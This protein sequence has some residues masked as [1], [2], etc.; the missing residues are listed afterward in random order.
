MLRGFLLAGGR[1]DLYKGF[2]GILHAYGEFL[3]VI[4]S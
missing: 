1:T 4:I 2:C 3:E